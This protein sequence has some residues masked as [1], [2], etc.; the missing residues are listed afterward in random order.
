MKKRN[1][2]LCMGILSMAMCCGCGTTTQNEDATTATPEATQE[3]T[4]TL[5]ATETP[6]ATDAETTQET[7]EGTIADEETTNTTESTNE[8]ESTSEETEIQEEQTE[9]ADTN[10][11]ADTEIDFS[12]LMTSIYE[13]NADSTNV[14]TVAENLKN[15]A[16]AEGAPSSSSAFESMANDWFDTM[17]DTEGKDIR[18]EFNE[19]FTTVT[20]TAQEMDESL[21]YDV[22]YL[23]VINGILAAIGE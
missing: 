20:S 1:M 9:T 4:E 21:E 15:Y 14:E 13:V 18:S 16:F 11:D 8:E 19:C 10:A 17:K 22:A 7:Q 2:I 12:S 5:E 6:E 23:N 3:V